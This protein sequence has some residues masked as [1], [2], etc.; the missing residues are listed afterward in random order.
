MPVTTALSRRLNVTILA[1]STD[2]IDYAQSPT[3]TSSGSLTGRSEGIVELA[4]CELLRFYDDLLSDLF[5]LCEVVA[6]NTSI[7]NIKK[8]RLG[9]IA[10]GCERNF[11]DH[12]IEGVCVN[13]TANRVWIQT[14]RRRHC[15]FE[16]FHAGIGE[17]GRAH[18]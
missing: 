3:S 8:S 4:G 17:I 12:R 5:E 7:L 6:D 11:A 10:V 14:L 18:V 13:I 16:N 1:G 9:P 15:L 2:Y